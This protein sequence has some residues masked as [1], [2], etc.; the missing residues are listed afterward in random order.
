MAQ[1]LFWSKHNKSLKGTIHKNCSI[2]TAK[3]FLSDKLK[4]SLHFVNI[5]F[6]D[7]F[8]YS[9]PFHPSKLFTPP[10]IP[11]RFYDFPI[12]LFLLYFLISN[13]ILETSL[14]SKVCVFYVIPQSWLGIY[15]YDRQFYNYSWE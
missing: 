6:V 9:L 3:E 4:I 8:I 10:L 14:V 13:I 5:C 2:V 1:L 12:K 15:F 11:K 7:S